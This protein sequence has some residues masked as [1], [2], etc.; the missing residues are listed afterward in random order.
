MLCT[1]IHVQ[2]LW[3]CIVPHSCSPLLR[4]HFDIQPIE[5]SLASFLHVIEIKK[6]RSY[7]YATGHVFVFGNVVVVCTIILARG[8]VQH[9]EMLLRIIEGE[10]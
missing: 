3:K 7:A 8:V 1:H 6:E 9:L 5:I 2:T 4:L 10:C